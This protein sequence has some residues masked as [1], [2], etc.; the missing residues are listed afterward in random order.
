MQTQMVVMRDGVRLATD[1]HMP[2][3][4]GPW[5]VIL[6]RTPYDRQGISGSEVALDRPDPLTRAELGR[7]MAARGYAVVMQDVRGRYGS[8]GQFEK[9]VNEAEDGVDTHRWLL[10]QPWCDGRICTM[11]LSYGAHTQLASAVAGAPGIAA[12]AIDTGGLM[13][14]W[15]HSVRYGG[16]FELK[17]VTWAFR[18]AAKAL[19]Q[20]G[21]IR[22]AK[23]LEATDLRAALLGGDWQPG[24]S[25]LALAP[26]YEAALLRLWGMRRD[27]P[28]LNLPATHAAAHF[29]RFPDVPVLLLGSWNDPYARNMLELAE[30]ISRRNTAPLRQIFGPWLHGRR[31]TGQ[32]GEADFGENATIDRATGRDWVNLR[33]D[34]FDHALGRAEIPLETDL[35][36]Q[37]SAGLWPAMTGR[38][39]QRRDEAA[40]PATAPVS[41]DD[42]TL[43]F[44]PTRPHPTPGGAVTSGGSLM[45]GGMYDQRL[46]GTLDHPGSVT[47]FGRPLPSDLVLTE[48]AVTADCRAEGVFDLHAVLVEKLACGAV[49]NITDGIRR[50]SAGR[51]RIELAPTFYR[52]QRG[53]RL[54]LIL[55]TSSFPRFDFASGLPY[56]VRVRDAILQCGSGPSPCE[57]G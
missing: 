29:N 14:A 46:M 1:I 33:L 12:M 18:H 17:Q 42:V 49:V 26:D 37:M 38:W 21:C 16:A 36:W 8:E 47:T 44:D 10:E 27:D 11:G 22:Q 41:M 7:I 4:A 35:F 2:D 23:A 52:A 56:A 32:A 30:A 57:R 51:V 39:T 6:E 13:D 9:Y 24:R 54:G 50:A 19:R 45:A 55:A 5:P 53:N 48:I 40:A 28:C 43:I 20:R 34:W 15:R 3:G 31:S 25:P